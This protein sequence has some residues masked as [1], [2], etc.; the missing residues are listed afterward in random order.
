VVRASG[1]EAGGGQVLAR[2]ALQVLG[3]L[4][5]HAGGDLFREQFEEKLGHRDL[6]GFLLIDPGLGAQLAEVADAADVAGALGDGDRAPGV[7]RLKR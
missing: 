2:H 4:G 7:I 1:R 5:L 6:R 3:G